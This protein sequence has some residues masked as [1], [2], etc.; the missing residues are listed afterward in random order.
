MD[1]AKPPMPD[2]LRTLAE[3]A[4]SRVHK[5]GATAP[6]DDMV[7]PD[8]GDGECFV[9]PYA[10]EDWELWAS[11]LLDTF[12]TRNLAVVNAFMSKLAAMLPPVWDGDTQTHLV[13]R[14]KLQLALSIICSL[15]P[16]NEAE[17]AIA[18]HCV[19]LHFVT[20]KVTER[21]GSQSWLDIKSASA[22][23][24]VTKAFAEQVKALRDLQSPNRAK[25][26]IIKVQKHVTVNHYHDEKH[27]HLPDRGGGDSENQS[28]AT[29]TLRAHT[30][31]A[32]EPA[33]CPALPCPDQG[34]NI[35]P[36]ARREGEK[37]V[38]HARLRGS[39]ER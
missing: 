15:K 9:S 13:D 27:V 30:T 14:E 16:R 26:Q 5:R 18:V 20:Y 6:I 1:D 37:A 35:V 11:L 31:P 28:Q 29:R 7:P 36:L 21:M 2:N 17:A 33:K 4:R 8:K 12:G 32:A 34:G 23:A 25:R 10:E 19:A 24:K 38:P 22:L 3:A 39:A